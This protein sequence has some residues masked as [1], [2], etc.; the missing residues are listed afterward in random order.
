MMAHGREVQPR[1]DIVGR[2][3]EEGAWQKA[4]LQMLRRC[5]PE[6]DYPKT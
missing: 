2:S 4:I 5:L 1:A 3:V 6:P